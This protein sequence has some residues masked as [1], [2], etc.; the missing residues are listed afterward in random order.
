MQEYKH[1]QDSIYEAMAA[2]LTST[3][4]ALSQEIFMN[5]LKKYNSL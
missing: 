5:W 3:F 1:K 4:E 2:E